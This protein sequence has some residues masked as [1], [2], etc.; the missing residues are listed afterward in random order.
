[1]QAVAAAAVAALVLRVL[2]VAPR[3]VLVARKVVGM[4]RVTP[5]WQQGRRR[6]DL[7]P[8]EIV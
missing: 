7:H 2:L 8:A 1:V 4:M 3:A 6:T 5:L